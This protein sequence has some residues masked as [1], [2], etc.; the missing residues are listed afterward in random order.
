MHIS[1]FAH[2]LKCKHC[3]EFH[4]TDKWP[5]NGDR[6]AFYYQREPGNI[7]LKVNCPHCKNDWYVVW[8]NDPGQ[9]QPFRGSEG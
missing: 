6:V 2:K 1:N 3:G 5:V 8:D 4:G 7:S 9:I